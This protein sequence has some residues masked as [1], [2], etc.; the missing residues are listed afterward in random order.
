MGNGVRRMV[1]F[2]IPCYL[3]RRS[4]K[5]S[6]PR[7]RRAVVDGSGTAVTVSDCILTLPP[8]LTGVSNFN[9]TPEATVEPIVMLVLLALKT[10]PAPLLLPSKIVRLKSSLPPKEPITS[11]SRV[12]V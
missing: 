5:A 8:L 3:R 11:E 7:P 10:C 9:M 12:I 1:G 2:A 6:P 4:I